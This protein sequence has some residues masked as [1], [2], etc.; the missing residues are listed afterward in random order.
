MLTYTV[1]FYL[2]TIKK[3]ET[4]KTVSV[5]SIS[6][7]FVFLY[8]STQTDRTK[9]TNVIGLI[10]ICFSLFFFAS[11]LANLKHVIRVKSSE[12]L[13]FSMILSSFIV[14]LLWFIYGEL[15]SDPFIQ[16]P[17][18]IGC[19]LLVIQLLLFIIYPSKTSSLTNVSSAMY[20][21]LDL[22]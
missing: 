8:S 16:I 7:A 22:L 2:F 12:S 1:I 21:Q 14:T 4:L 3:R 17:N 9:A 18:F 6:L 13:P 11:P 15:I 20:K 10:G 5:S 19:L